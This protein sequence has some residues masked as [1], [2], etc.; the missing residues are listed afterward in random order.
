MG[1]Q[2]VISSGSS[3]TTASSLSSFVAANTTTPPRLYEERHFTD[4]MKGIEEEDGMMQPAVA[5]LL[6]KQQLPLKPPSLRSSTAAQISQVLKVH[7]SYF[8]L[9]KAGSLQL[10]V[11]EGEGLGEKGKNFKLLSDNVAPMEQS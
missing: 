10:L 11:P 9:I 2:Q 7:S 5:P 8:W 4:N 3:E 6:L 1:P